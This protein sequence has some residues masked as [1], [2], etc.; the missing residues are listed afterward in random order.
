[1]AVGSA[2]GEDIEVSRVVVW[3]LSL[4]YEDASRMCIRDIER[5]KRVVAYV[6]SEWL[7]KHTE[8][9]V[10]YL[11]ELELTTQ[12]VL[13]AGNSGLLVLKNCLCENSGR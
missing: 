7:G 8:L 3:A 6:L 10:M 1:M 4:A 13:G 5:T 9:G 2:P 12:Q 11:S